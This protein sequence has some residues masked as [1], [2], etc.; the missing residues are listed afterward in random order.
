MCISQ[1]IYP[2]T[3]HTDNSS[4]TRVRNYTKSWF[5]NRRVKLYGICCPAGLSYLKG[6]NV[7]DAKIFWEVWDNTIL[8]VYMIWVHVCILRY[9]SRCRLIPCP[10]TSQCWLLMIA[11]WPEHLRYGFLLLQ[12]HIAA[13]N[14]QRGFFLYLY[15]HLY[16]VITRPR[17]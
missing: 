1:D 8:Q 16:L 11:T 6:L 17:N 12:E 7:H 10:G 2:G 5:F 15:L 14:V 9:I 3:Y 4:Y 13:F